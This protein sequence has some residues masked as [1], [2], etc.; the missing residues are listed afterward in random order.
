MA[1]TLK[2]R[3]KSKDA[4]DTP[5]PAPVPEELAEGPVVDIPEHD[6][7]H[8]Y[9]L[10]VG[11]PIE[12]ARTELDSPALAALADGGIEL[13]VPLISHGELI[14]TLNLG[15]R[16]SE[17]PYSTD[18]RKLLEG[19]AAQVAPAIQVAQLVR[20]QEEEAKERERIEQELRVA[21][22]IQ[23]TL[24]PKELPALNGWEIDA[25]YSSARQVGGDFYDFV[26]LADDRIGLV[27]GDVTDKGIPAALVMATCRSTLRAAARQHDDPGLVLAEVNDA[28]VPEIPPAMFITCFYGILDPATGHLRFANAGHNLPYVHNAGGVTELRATGMPLGLIPGSEYEVKEFSLSPAETMLLSSDGIAEAHDASGEMFGF[29]RL[30]GLV[31]GHPGGKDL[32]DA[33]LG[34]LGRFTGDREQED[35]VTMV[36]IRRSASPLASAGPVASSQE[37]TEDLT[38]SFTI[39]SEPGNEREVMERVVKLVTS[40]GLSAERVQRLGTA[41]AEATMNAIEHGNQN[42]AELPVEVRVLVSSER[43]LVQIRDEGGGRLV[44]PSESPDIEAKLAGEQSPRGWGLFL[45]ENM[46]DRMDVRSDDHHN[47]IE[48]EMRLTEV[49]D[50]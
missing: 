20:Q 29:S 31:A 18:D 11:G 26:P 21:A 40:T 41:V 17:Q 25:Y 12:P 39:A 35:D 13:I 30:I 22:L 36:A 8:S 27:V 1:M 48:L 14:G 37:P 47:T 33:V 7:L 28:L 6:P 46:V 45:I 44:Q 34:E 43:V 5:V 38:D 9:L 49:D 19:L 3:R 23:Q 24:L 50:A 2:R 15:H 16:L 32:I 42:R 4:N 10:Q